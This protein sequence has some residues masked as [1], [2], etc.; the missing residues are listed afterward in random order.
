MNIQSIQNILRI[1]AKLK[2]DVV[3][4]NWRPPS[5]SEL[6]PMIFD[7]RITHLGLEASNLNVVF[8]FVFI[9]FYSDI[10]LRLFEFGLIFDILS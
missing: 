1:I 9:Y 7:M 3:Y 8:M 4:I 5:L 10:K 6:T 2:C